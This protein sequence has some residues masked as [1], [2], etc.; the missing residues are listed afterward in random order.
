LQA[1]PTPAPGLFGVRPPRLT[2]DAAGWHA[3]YLSSQNPPQR[4]PLR[5]S[6]LKPAERKKGMYAWW[7]SRVF[8]DAAPS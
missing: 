5:F 7:I 3:W 8:G 6:W 4:M 1:A 2:F